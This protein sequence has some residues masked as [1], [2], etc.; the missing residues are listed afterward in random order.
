MVDWNGTPFGHGTGRARKAAPEGKGT[1][2]DLEQYWARGQHVRSDGT[3]VGLKDLPQAYL[4]NIMKK[5]AEE[6]RDVSAI[7]LYITSDSE[8]N[9]T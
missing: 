6:G 4:R 8:D 2:N 9:S 3:Q 1:P 5:H 7:G